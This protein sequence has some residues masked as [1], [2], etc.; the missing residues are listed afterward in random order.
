MSISSSRSQLAFKKTERALLKLSS[1]QTAEVVHRFRTAS[2][3]LQTLLEHFLRE[4]DRNQKKLLKMLNQIRRRAGKVRDLDVQLAA[5]RSLK[6]PQQPRRKTQLVQGL[7]ELRE[8]HEKKLRKMLT[9][10]V[11]RELQKRLKRGSNQVR[12]AGGQDALKIAREM[13]NQVVRPAGPLRE[14]VLHTYR[15]MM[16]RARYAAEFAPNSAEADYFIAE[17]KKLQDALGNWHDWL[18]L[19]E[20]AAKRLGEVS[21]SSL[22]ALLHNVTAGKFRLAVA[23]VSASPTLR[24]GNAVLVATKQSRKVSANSPTLIERIESAA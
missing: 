7:I 6:V 1:T 17:V 20:A 14:D 10:S 24:P 15:T 13:L 2:C 4:R 16:K 3:R 23:A 19:T 18:I 9:S 21:Q 22:V 8:K 11:I 5:L 12:L